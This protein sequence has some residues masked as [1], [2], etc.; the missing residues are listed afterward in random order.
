MKRGRGLLKGE[1]GTTLVRE[2]E[3]WMQRQGIV[4]PARMTAMFLPGLNLG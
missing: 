1:S 4:A 3:E 2:A